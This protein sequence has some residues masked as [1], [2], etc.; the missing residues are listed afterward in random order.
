MTKNEVRPI[1][2]SRP[3]PDISREL[4]PATGVPDIFES[5]VIKL[6]QFA[7]KRVFIVGDGPKGKGFIQGLKSATEP[8]IALNATVLAGLPVAWWMCF[9]HRV[10]HSPWFYQVH[11]FKGQILYS[12]R[13]NNSLWR[14]MVGAWKPHYQFRY[15]HP[16]M[17]TISGKDFMP[18]H[19]ATPLI[20]GYLRG[21]LTVAGC[22]IQFA[23]WAGA[24]EITLV[25]VD[26]FGTGHVYGDE[27]EDKK[28]YGGQWE[29]AGKLSKLCHLL[30][31]EHGVTVNTLSETKLEIPYV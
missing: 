22:A 5:S 25:G 27:V 12:T 28:I 21:G 30:R 1:F 23:Y 11:D 10:I 9:D 14:T 7:G 17:R 31:D 15:D 16:R 20:N 24:T 26:M 6:K 8:I 4:D 18:D 2:D 13:L 19:S 29:W 3:N